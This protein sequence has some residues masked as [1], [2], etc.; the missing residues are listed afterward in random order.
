MVSLL[1]F[2]FRH[3]PLLTSVIRFGYMRIFSSCRSI[4][5]VVVFECVV[6]GIVSSIGSNCF[7]WRVAV[8]RRGLQNST[9]ALRIFGYHL[10]LW[11]CRESMGFFSCRLAVYTQHRSF[12]IS[13]RLGY[14]IHVL[15]FFGS[16]V[17]MLTL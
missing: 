17:S 15:L 6:L 2:Y 12:H 1:S 5:F 3:M 16:L 7:T 4:S 8:K 9:S 11:F 14:P 10:Q 13:L